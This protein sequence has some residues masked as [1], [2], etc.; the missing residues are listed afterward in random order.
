MTLSAL[1]SLVISVFVVKGSNVSNP[2]DVVSAIGDDAGTQSLN[3]ASPN[4]TTTSANDLLI[5]FAKSSG[6]VTFTSGSGFTAQPAASS[7]FLD[8]ESGLAITPGS[9]NATFLVNF[10]VTWQAAVV[11]VRPSAT[12][13][14]S[15]TITLSWSTSSDNVGVTG[16]LVERCQ[17]AA[18]SNFAQIATTPNTTFTDTGLTHSTTYSYRV[19]ATDAASNLSSYSNTVVVS[20]QP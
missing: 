19:R 3:V 17:G 1:Q 18:C 14:T 13:S 8:A 20:T 16:Y 6:G 7:N 4:V 10:N 9:Y 11:A 12:S 15:T 2:I 5:G